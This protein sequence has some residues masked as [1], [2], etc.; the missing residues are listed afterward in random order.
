MANYSNITK[1]QRFFYN[2]HASKVAFIGAGVSHAELIRL[3]LQKG[4]DVTVLDKKDKEHFDSELYDDLAS[5]GA[6]FI[7]GDNYLD[8]LDDFDVV[9][10]TP[11]MYYNNPKLVKARDNGVIVTSE[12]E[13][14]FELCPCK[15]YAVTGSDGKT[16]T[17]TL[18][19]NMLKTEGYTVWLG[20]NI[21]KALL[22]RI[23]S[24]SESDVAV[25]ELSSFQL[26]SMRESPD[27]AVITNIA[28]NHLDVHGTMDEYIA[29]KCN[30]LDHQNAFSRSVLNKDN[31]ETM[32][33]AKRVR[34]KLITF[35]RLGPV[36]HGAY[37]DS[38]RVI[39]YNDGRKIVKVMNASDIKI[40]GEHNVENYLAAISAVWNDVSV[41]SMCKVAKTFSGVEHRI[42]FVRELNGVRYYNDSIASNPTRVIAGLKSFGKGK[43]IVQIAG[44]YDKKIPFDPLAVPVNKYV[45]VLILIGDTADKI[46]KAVTSS[47]DYSP[48]TLKIFHADTMEQAVQIAKNNASRGDVVTLS[49]AC[50]SFD[51]YPNFEARGRDYKAIVNSL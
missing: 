42:E 3:F 40:P 31:K 51:M 41:K 9:Y 43:K 23:E 15:I 12:M 30:I 21:G 20:G 19:A 14:F 38:D 11:G 13:S 47:Y 29:A 16:T 18:I 46:E 45:K 26:M 22:P 25:V 24:I 32:N 7:L 17:T 35:S 50:A 2:L 37:L 5:R 48:R 27:V 34:G 39:C 44:G 4:I 36:E 8:S 6:K 33:L 1:V 10:R 49:P 28:P